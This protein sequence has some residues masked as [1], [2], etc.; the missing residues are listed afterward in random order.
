MRSD[1]IHQFQRCAVSTLHAGAEVGYES[2]CAEVQSTPCLIRR[3]G[4]VVLQALRN[5]QEEDAQHHVELCPMPLY[6]VAHQIHLERFAHI[7]LG[8]VVVALR[9]KKPGQFPV[10]AF[11]RGV[12]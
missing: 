12:C 8:R 10:R 5:E 4:A 7:G 9:S 11:A 3:T 6:E 2:D 1:A